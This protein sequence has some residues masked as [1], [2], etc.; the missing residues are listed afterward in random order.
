MLKN[1]N[2]LIIGGTGSFG[3]AFVPMTLEKYNPKSILIYFRDEIKQWDMVKKFSN[4]SRVKFI[5][6]D[7]DRLS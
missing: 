7:R 5:I 1:F 4:D 6:G 2:I 3:Y